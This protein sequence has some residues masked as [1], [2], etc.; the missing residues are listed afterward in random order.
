MAI[1]YPSQLPTPLREG[2]GLNTTSPLMRTKMDSGRSRQRRKFKNV[3]V[4][5]SAAWL[6]NTPQAQIFESFYR[7]EISDGAQWFICKLQTP[8]GLQNYDVRFV[9]IYSGPTL[10][11]LSSWRYTAQIEIRERFTIPYDFITDAHEYLL[12]SDWLDIATNKEWP[13]A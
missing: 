9:D 8:Y 6:L 12:H 3:P 7:D 5:I 2:Y 4:I 13:Q 10:V 1:E 11:G